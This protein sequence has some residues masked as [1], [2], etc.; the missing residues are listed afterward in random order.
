MRPGRRASVTTPGRPG[1]RACPRRPRPGSPRPGRTRSGTLRSG[2]PRRARNLLVGGHPRPGHQRHPRTR[3]RIR[4]GDARRGHVRCDGIR[5]SRHTGPAA[6]PAQRRPA[7]GR[8]GRRH[9]ARPRGGD[10][11]AG[12]AARP[13][14]GAA[15]Q[16][17]AAPP[18]TR[19]ERF[20]FLAG[21][22]PSRAHRPAPGPA[23]RQP[24]NSQ[25]GAG[26]PEPWASCPRSSRSRQPPLS[27]YRSIV[28]P[29]DR[30]RF[31]SNDCTVQV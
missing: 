27:N 16:G 30:S 25:H 4:P 18:S 20:A 19:R 2:A 1:D 29:F 7:L 23:A 24:E 8:P 5:H 28:Q 9:P 22:P 12:A 14:A 10:A 6:R 3:R 15:P 11:P 31:R 13:P 26:G 21:I 17:P